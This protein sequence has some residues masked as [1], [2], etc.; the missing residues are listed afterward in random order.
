MRGQQL[1]DA[2][3]QFGAEHEIPGIAVSLFDAERVIAQATT[4]VR[5]AEDPTAPVTPSTL[6]RL[7]SVSKPLMG[8]VIAALVEAGRLDYADHVRKYLPEFT[9][10]G[11][12]DDNGITLRHL[13]SH[14]SGLPY[15]VRIGDA[16]GRNITSLGQFVHAEANRKP[17]VADPGE[18]Y[19][20]SNLGAAIAGHIL[21]TVT[22]RSFGELMRQQLFDRLDMTSTTY[23]P[24]VALTRPTANGNVM[25]EDATLQADHRA[26]G[27]V[28]FQP[29]S[30][31]FTTIRDLTLFGQAH[32]AATPVVPEF[33]S[34]AARERLFARQADIGLDTGLGYGM[35]FNVHPQG[36]VSHEGVFDGAF[37]RIELD[38]STG[39]GLCWLDTRGP[40]LT[41]ARY[42]L[43]AELFRAGG[44]RDSAREATPG[45]PVSALPVRGTFVRQRIEVALD[46]RQDG[47][48]CR[49]DGREVDLRAG[50]DGLWVA[51]YDRDLPAILR[52][53][54]GSTQVCVL[55]V[56]TDHSATATHVLINGLALTN[57]EHPV[58][59][60]DSTK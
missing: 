9:V 7:Y 42:R 38:R 25:S 50:P 35:T 51:P 13:L 53:F 10:Y 43:M 17:L 21:E 46:P 30:G 8:T 58:L 39:V 3:H 54:P 59:A 26:N 45:R 48:R 49:V 56:N 57:V 41:E 5:S 1:N 44:R 47:L 32:L 16:G 22:S 28:G 6:F 20:Y 55:P 40:E 19:S 34:L 33:P 2:L 23:D 14:T 27:I 12:D 15:G 24:T 37:A 29:S 52:P 31:C 4:G 36:V 60:T 11:R 18:V